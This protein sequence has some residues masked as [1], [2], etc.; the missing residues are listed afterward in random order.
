VA[1]SFD[2]ATVWS[3]IQVEIPLVMSPDEKVN[4]SAIEVTLEIPTTLKHWLEKRSKN[5]GLSE[6]ELVTQVL[7]T[8]ILSSGNNKFYEGS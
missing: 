5:C 4:K 8:H 7:E 2:L 1:L 3:S 6:S